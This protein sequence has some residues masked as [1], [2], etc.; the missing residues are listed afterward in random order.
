MVYMTLS[1]PFR[2]ISG[3]INAFIVCQKYSVWSQ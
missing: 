3:T 1:G 2:V